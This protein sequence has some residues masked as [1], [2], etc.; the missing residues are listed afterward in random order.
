MLTPSARPQTVYAYKCKH[1]TLVINGKGNSVTLDNCQSCACVF[2]DM[3][4][5]FETVRCKKLQ[6][7]CKGFVPTVQIDNTDG[8]MVRSCAHAILT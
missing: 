4:G 5:G 3:V 1:V 6:C 8:E 2:D 7:Q